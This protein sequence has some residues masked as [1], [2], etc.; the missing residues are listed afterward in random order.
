MQLDYTLSLSKELNRLDL[1]YETDG[2]ILKNYWFRI[3]M[4]EKQIFNDKMHA[5][6][7]YEIHLCLKGWARFLVDGK[8]SCLHAGEMAFVPK[9]KKH[10]IFDISDDLEKVVWGY[11]LLPGK[12][13]ND[14]PE[15]LEVYRGLT[16]FC[17]QPIGKETL[18]PFALILQNLREK[19]ILWFECIKLYTYCFLVEQ[20]RLIFKG[21]MNKETE[22]LLKS[23]I[24][25]ESIR[26]Y[27]LDNLQNGVTVQD[28]ARQMA[29]SERQLSRICYHEFGISVG[30]Y[31]RQLKMEQAKRLLE[32]TDLTIEE[33]AERLGYSDRFVFS[34]AFSGYEGMS[35][36]QFRTSLKT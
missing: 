25:M 21:T 9:R 24:K 31:I 13:T 19:K 8:E 35:P 29:L 10:Q 3:A 6:S 1:M 7:F 20:T 17:I 15:L 36:A 32:E 30:E 14:P 5:H 18:Y 12:E 2:V 34:K 33:I 16:G 27:I 26:L 23:R 4:K 28:V 22:P 11:D